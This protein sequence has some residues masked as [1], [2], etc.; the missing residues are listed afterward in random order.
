[1]RAEDGIRAVVEARVGD[2]ELIEWDRTIGGRPRPQDHAYWV[3]QRGVCRSGS[4]ATASAWDMATR[5]RA[6]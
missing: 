5:K 6:G 4:C 2:P 1:M 3:E